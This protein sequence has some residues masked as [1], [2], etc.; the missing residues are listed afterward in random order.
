[1]SK[2]TKKGQGILFKP[3]PKTENE[4]AQVQELQLKKKLL[5]DKLS[6]T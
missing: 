5:E 3:T 6:K 1:M 4:V 2:K